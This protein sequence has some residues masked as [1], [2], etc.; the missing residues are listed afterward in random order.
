MSRAE[1]EKG[2]EDI[3]KAANA[4]ALSHADT[5]PYLMG[6]LQFSAYKWW[7]RWFLDD[8]SVLENL[9]DFTGPI[10]YHNGNIDSQTPGL[11]EQAIL[12]TS[13][14]QMKSTPTF[15]LH[16]GKGHGLSND[17]LYGPLDEN[18]ADLIAEHILLWVQ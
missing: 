10:E 5:D 7:K 16:L 18:S 9:K 8:V 12:Q 4:D 1:V 15:I 3:Y 11:R 2:F 13:K 6:K 17:P 14:I